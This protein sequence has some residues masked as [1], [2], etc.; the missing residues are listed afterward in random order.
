VP[1]GHGFAWQDVRLVIYARAGGRCELC[2]KQLGIANMEGHHRRTRRLGPD[3]PC[4]AIALCSDCHHGPNVHGGPETAREL[5]L[6]LPRECTDP[7]AEI[8]V[9]LHGQR[10]VLLNCDGTTRDVERP[11]E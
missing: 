5:R 6:I 8:P 7:P 10:W 2:G 11:E 9:E 4:N 1:G 3:C